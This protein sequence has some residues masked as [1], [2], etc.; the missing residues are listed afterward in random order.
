MEQEE[1][2]LF[3]LR[4]AKVLEPEATSEQLRQ[5]ACAT[6]PVTTRPQLSW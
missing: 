2:M 3:L 4:R 1:G 5:F 6:C